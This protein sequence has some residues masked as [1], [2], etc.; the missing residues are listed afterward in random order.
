MAIATGTALLAGGALAAGASVYGASKASKAGKYAAD[1]TAAETREQ[2]QLQREIFEQT[3]QDNATRLAVGDSSLMALAGGLGLPVSMTGRPAMASDPKTAFASTAA[4]PSMTGGA[5][6]SAYLAQNPDVAAWAQ[7]GHGDPSIPI[8]QQSLEQRAA[9]HYQNSGQGEG[10]ALPTVT[11]TGQEPTAPADP[12]APPAGYADPT[13]PDG[14]SV[15]PRP[16]LGAGPAAY[17]APA[18]ATFRDAPSLDLSLSSFRASPDYEFRVQ[19][20]NRMLDAQVSNTGGRF[21]GTRL[22]AAQT[23]GQNLADSEYTDWRNAQMQ[24]YAMDLQQYNQD[25]GRADNIYESDRGFGYGQSRDARGD[26]TQDRARSDGLYADDRAYTTGRYDTRNSTLLNLA[27]FGAQAAGQNQSAAQSF[28]QNS[29]NLAMTAANARGQAA[30]NS[31]N[32]WNQGIGNL[33]TSGAY[34]AGQY[35]GGK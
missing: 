33:M 11:M 27:G 35:F 4:Q 6:W 31:A 18:R 20:G 15:G 21:S 32:A 30:I 7:S 13:A 17:V 34:L 26:F 2:T 29:G 8:E 14:Y 23:Y 19:Q 28:A 16:D 12:N 5:D 25:R 9:Y 22:K 1:Q 3:R 24:R 10:R